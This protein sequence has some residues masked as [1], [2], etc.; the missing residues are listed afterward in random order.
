MALLL[1]KG[2]DF[3]SW[4]GVEEFAVAYREAAVRLATRKHPGGIAHLLELMEDL[5][6]VVDQ[7]NSAMQQE[8]DRL[9]DEL[10]HA[11]EQGQLRSLLVGFYDRAYHHF[12]RFGSPVALFRMSETFLQALAD[13]CLR[14][15]QQQIEE[16]LPPVALILMGPAGR[17]EATRF[18]RV[19]LALVWDGEASEELMVQLGEELAAWLRV[20]GVNLEETITPL[21]SD[22]RGSLEQWQARLETAAA[23]NDQRMLIELL[24]LADRTVL[25]SED[26]VADRFGSICQTYLRQRIFIGNL[27]DRCLTLSNGIGMMGSLKLAKSGP[28]RGG[29]SLL[30]HAFLP[31]AAAVGGLC[32]MHGVDLVGT[33]ERL[34]GLVRISKLDVDLAER[35]L[36]AWHCFSGHRISLEQSA[37]PGQD[38]RDILYLLPS[39]LKA[40][41]AERLR[42]SLETV[43]DLQRYLQVS[44]GAYT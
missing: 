32:L 10:A 35:T 20:C 30:D 13:C 4:R 26:S 23:R 28:H 43:A 27:V 14:L 15:A 37:I 22:W 39:T 21:N 7:E 6:A 41:E 29:F 38:C 1:A 9:V 11:S 8:L 19:Q 25:V 17:R 44:F 42:I 24:R 12:A 3:A 2:E 5:I 36:H 34:R 31:L 16:P 40:A 18:C 33:P